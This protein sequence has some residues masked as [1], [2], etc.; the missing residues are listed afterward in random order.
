MDTINGINTETPRAFD[1]NNIDKVIFE[2]VVRAL[3]THEFRV[4][5]PE[6]LFQSSIITYRADHGID[7]EIPQ[8]EEG[9]LHFLI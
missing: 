5:L 3:N 4:Q 6:T 1:D 7:L 9:K 2:R 8:Q